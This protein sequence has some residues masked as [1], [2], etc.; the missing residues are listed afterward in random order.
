MDLWTRRVRDWVHCLVYLTV[1]SLPWHFGRRLQTNPRLIS[2]NL[3]VQC[4]SQLVGAITIYPLLARDVVVLL[5]TPHGIQIDRNDDQATSVRAG[6]TRR[7]SLHR[8]VVDLE[9]KA[10]MMG[11]PG[12]LIFLPWG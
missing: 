8:S 11:Q 2:F 1:L 9:L 3:C 12:G 5:Y 4:R 10:A 6:G 7:E